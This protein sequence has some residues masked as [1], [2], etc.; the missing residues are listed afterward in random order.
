M[1]HTPVTP[2]T[3]T[4]A[5]TW[6]GNHSTNGTASVLT[7]EE[8]D[9]GSAHT[10]EGNHSTNDTAHVLTKEGEDNGMDNLA[11]YTVMTLLL[12]GSWCS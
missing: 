5:H 11:V 2:T 10:R 12:M 7:R 6:E 4:P 3:N 1:I 9:N 8:E